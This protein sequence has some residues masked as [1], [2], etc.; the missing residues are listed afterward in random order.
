VSYGVFVPGL[1]RR[2][3]VRDIPPDGDGTREAIALILDGQEP[4]FDG[5]VRARMDEGR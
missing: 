1:D 5:R 4:P 3:A 2:A